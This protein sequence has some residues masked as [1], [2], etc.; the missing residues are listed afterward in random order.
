MAKHN[1]RFTMLTVYDTP[2]RTEKATFQGPI[3]LYRQRGTN[4]H[5]EVPEEYL[6]RLGPY[7]YNK[8]DRF[9]DQRQAEGDRQQFYRVQAEGDC[10]QFY[11]EQYHERRLG[12]VNDVS[13]KHQPSSLSRA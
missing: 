13:G 1:A 3:F 4:V 6:K 11:M 12:V 2:D 9:A 5:R 7:K 8:N 10:Q